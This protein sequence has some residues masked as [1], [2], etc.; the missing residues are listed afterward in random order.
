VTEKVSRADFLQWRNNVVTKE[1]FD[2]FSEMAIAVMEEML[3]PQLIS[4]P[5]GQLRLNELMG[6]RNALNE[7]MSFEI[8]E[9][10]DYDTQGESTRI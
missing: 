8:I 1:V 4:S 5:T 9:S 7:V 2:V 6:Y 3:S 10:D